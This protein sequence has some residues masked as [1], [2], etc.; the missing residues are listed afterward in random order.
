MPNLLLIGR[1]YLVTL[2][3]VSDY[4]KSIL[5]SLDFFLR[6]QFQLLHSGSKAIVNECILRSAITLR[7]ATSHGGRAMNSRL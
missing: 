3:V 7:S 1:V 4:Q 6:K 5:P 2:Q